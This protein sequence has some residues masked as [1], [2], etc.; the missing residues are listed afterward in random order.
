[1]RETLL[2]TALARLIAKGQEMTVR[3]LLDSGSQRSYIRKN[4]AE[5]LDMQGP[6]ELLRFQGRFKGGDRGPFYFQNL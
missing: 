4:I 3:V 5:A 1:M 2:Q 6:S